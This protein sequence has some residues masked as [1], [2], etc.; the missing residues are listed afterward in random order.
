M[1][2]IAFNINGLRAI[3]QKEFANDM[4]NL[5]PDVLVLEETKLSED[6]HLDFPYA[7]KGYFPYWSVS[8]ERKGYSGVAIL[9]KVEPLNVTYGLKDGKYDNEGRVITLEFP[10][11]YLIGAYVPNSGEGLKRLDFRMGF[12]DDL[13]AYMKELDAKKPVILTG[14][15][16]VAHEEIDIKNPQANIHNAGFTAEERQKFTRLLS[17]GFVDTYRSLYP[18]KVE[19]SWWSYR[20]NA[21]ANNAG[22]RI[23]YFVVSSRLMGQVIDSKIHNEIHGSDHCPIELDLKD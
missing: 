20:F 18:T 14:D 13:L 4:A 23:D 17:E 5:N 6:L 21:R 1:K 11:F 9:S 7:P 22:W 12:E 15:L 19:Y 3:L 10:S 8:K 16:N 2:I